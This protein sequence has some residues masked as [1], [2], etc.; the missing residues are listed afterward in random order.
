[1]K[2]I[3]D[4]LL[5]LFTRNDDL[6]PAMMFPSIENGIVYATDAYVAISIPEDELSLKYIKQEEYPNVHRLI[7]DI[8]NKKLSSIKVSVEELAKELAKCRVEADKIE[9]KCKECNGDGIVQWEYDDKIGTTHYENYDCPACEGKGHN[10]KES[11]FPRISLLQQEDRDGNLLK[12]KIG[13]L[14]YHPFQLY[15]LFMVAAMNGYKDIDIHYNKD[16]YG[17]TISYFGNVK[18][19]VMAMRKD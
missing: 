10:E 16:N 4:F 3:N 14:Y 15:R 19:L 12:I 18:V 5:G 8:E 17:S 13:D 7:S 11:P 1:M 2:A 6:R 9:I